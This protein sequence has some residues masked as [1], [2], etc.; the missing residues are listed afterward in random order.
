MS[1]S[2]RLQRGSNVPM[3]IIDLNFITKNIPKSTFIYQVA[4][5]ITPIIP[6]PK[7]CY[8]CQAFGHV[9]A[10]CRSTHFTCEHCGERHKSDDCDSTRFD[11]YCINCAGNHKSSSSSCLVFRYEFEI[12]RERYIYNRTRE[13]AIIILA[14]KGILCSTPEYRNDNSADSSPSPSISQHDYTDNNYKSLPNA[15]VITIT[16]EINTDKDK[17]INKMNDAHTET[18]SGSD[19]ITQQP[20]PPYVDKNNLE[21]E[22]EGG[23]IKNANRMG[24]YTGTNNRTISPKDGDQEM[25]W[26]SSP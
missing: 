10:Q 15:D 14:Q 13:E 8:K 26:D 21:T 20:M 16:G 9:T 11:S 23:Q 22:A 6:P 17:T 19:P 5:S 12:M 4:H 2:R 25:C 3:N 24:M 7:R 18:A 1:A